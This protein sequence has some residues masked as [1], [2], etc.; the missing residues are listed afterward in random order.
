MNFAKGDLPRASRNASSRDDF[1]ESLE[2]RRE[3]TPLH[4]NRATSLPPFG[5]AG[6]STLECRSN[7][8]GPRSRA[9][10]ASISDG[11]AM[12]EPTS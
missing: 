1:F 11:W 7:G 9:L 6:V 2:K 12:N 5:K 3:T 10:K 4:S 8:A